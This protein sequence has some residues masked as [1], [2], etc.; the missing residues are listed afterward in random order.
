MR[1]SR[2]A[3]LKAMRG[4]EDATVVRPDGRNAQIKFPQ[5]IHN[6]PTEWGMSD[7]QSKFVDR[8]CTLLAPKADPVSAHDARF[9]LPFYNIDAYRSENPSQSGSTRLALL[10]SLLLKRTDS[11][12]VAAVRSLGHLRDAAS[13]CLEH[14]DDDNPLLLTVTQLMNP[15]QSTRRWA[16]ANTG[17]EAE[18]DDP[19]LTLFNYQ[20]FGTDHSEEGDERHKSDYNTAKM[21]SE[22]DHD[23]NLLDG[24][25]RDIWATECEQVADWSEECAGLGPEEDRPLS[26]VNDAMAWDMKFGCLV[27]R[28]AHIA[29]CVPKDGDPNLRKVLI[30]SEFAD[31]AHYLNAALSEALRSD[32]RLNA[33]TGRLAPTIH[34]GRRPKERII[35]NFAPLTAGST[36]HVHGDN[37]GCYDILVST[38]VLAEGLNLQ[39]ASKVIN[40]D[41][42]W[43][44]MRV[45]QRIGRVDRLGS[46]TG[47]VETDCFFPAEDHAAELSPDDTEDRWRVRDTLRWKLMV[48][49]EALGAQ[50]ICPQLPGGGVQ[51]L[52]ADTLQQANAEAYES[53]KRGGGALGVMAAQRRVEEHYTVVDSLLDE[54]RSRLENLPAGVHACH[55]T[56]CVTLPTYLFCATIPGHGSEV[57]AVC[58]AGPREGE[59]PTPRWQFNP[60][61]PADRGLLLHDIEPGESDQCVPWPDGAL[62]RAFNA[63]QW[64]RQRLGNRDGH[65]PRQRGTRRRDAGIAEAVAVIDKMRSKRPEREL[66]ALRDAVSGPRWSDEILR[67][68]RSLLRDARKEPESHQYDLLAEYAEVRGMLRS[69]PVEEVRPV[70][71]ESLLLHSWILLLPDGGT[72]RPYRDADA[73][74]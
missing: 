45:V 15:E 60:E 68:L 24:L 5:V 31:T 23:L 55:M 22:L 40:Y 63:W 70:Q 39:Q 56:D 59:L 32:P 29:S 42:P 35:N 38:D 10:R 1:R 34:G 41:M 7:P 46:V 2:S 17:T 67:G 33:Y 12:P 36:G 3:V 62:E 51:V 57:M 8:V 73:L 61:L 53:D 9:R 25:L 48:A 71:G 4:D 19:V 18:D 64:A 43:N 14:L 44:P 20:D 11:S 6:D 66:C 65:R 37:Y 50:A 54:D 49:E 26:P 30:F 21:R 74:P 52:G 72:A 13:A 28:L 27:G 16:P 58:D 47:R 69:A